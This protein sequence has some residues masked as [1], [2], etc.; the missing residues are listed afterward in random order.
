M[1]GLTPETARTSLAGRIANAGLTEARSPL[2]VRNESAPRIDRSFAVLP[3]ASAAMTQR[4]RE[5]HRMTMVYTVQ[6]CHKLNPSDGQS[7]PDLSLR[8]YALAVRY[9]LQPGTDVTGPGTIDIGPATFSYV[10]GGAYLVSAFDVSLSFD[11]PLD[12]AGAG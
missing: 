10:G 3:K 12:F 6:L 4:G 5:R 7:A 11:F 8:D 1:V 2:G 9:L